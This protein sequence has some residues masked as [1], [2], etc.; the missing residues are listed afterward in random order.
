MDAMIPVWAIL[1][2]GAIDDVRDPAIPDE[3]RG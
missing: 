3:A 2:E 1:G